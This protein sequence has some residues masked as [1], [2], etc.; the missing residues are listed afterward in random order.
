MCLVT[1]GTQ[2]RYTLHAAESRRR[3]ASHVIY[4]LLSLTSLH[5]NRGGDFSLRVGMFS[6]VSGSNVSTAGSLPL[7]G[8][9][10]ASFTTFLC[11]KDVAAR[12][13]GPH[14]GDE[15]QPQ[16]A[17]QACPQ[18][19]RCFHQKHHQSYFGK[20]NDDKRTYA[21]LRFKCFVVRCRQTAGLQLI[22]NLT[23][24]NSKKCLGLLTDGNFKSIN[25]ILSRINHLKHSGKRSTTRFNIQ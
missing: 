15:V 18:F 5:R 1:F 9:R 20:S 2:P 23:M 14:V 24:L 25:T 3:P 21:L 13:C 4:V 8:F 12:Q 10:P 22:L 16:Q 7:P 17:S 19:P 11:K 6:C